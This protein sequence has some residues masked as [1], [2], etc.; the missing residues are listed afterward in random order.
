M[1][2]ARVSINRGRGLGAKIAGFGVEIECAD[3]VRAMCAVELH[4]ALDALN[5]VGFH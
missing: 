5:F 1:R 3:A 4:A 2:S